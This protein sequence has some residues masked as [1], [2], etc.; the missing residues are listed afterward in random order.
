MAGGLKGICFR[1]FSSAKQ[2]FIIDKN[3]IMLHPF[4]KTGAF[5]VINRVIPSD[6]Y[7]IIRRPEF[8]IIPGVRLF[9]SRSG[10]NAAFNFKMFH[11]ELESFC[12]T[13]TDGFSLDKAAVSSMAQRFCFRSRLLI[14][15]V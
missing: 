11:K 13:F 4:F 5:A 2:K 15:C 8:H 12:I 9:A 7:P 6:I 14:I 10:A 1:K 3:V